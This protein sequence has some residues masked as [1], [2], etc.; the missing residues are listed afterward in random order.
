MALFLVGVDVCKARLDVYLQQTR[1]HRQYPNDAEGCRRLIA[2]VAKAAGGG[3]VLVVY[4]ATSIY[5]GRLRDALRQAGMPSSRANPRRSR[6]FARAAGLLAK[7]DKVDAVMLAEMGSALKLKCDAPPDPAAAA[8]TAL[9][10]RRGQL[11][12]ERKRLKT[13]M[14]QAEHA[15][16]TDILAE[17]KTQL[18]DLN[19]RIA[20]YGRKL[21]KRLKAAPAMARRAEI[22]RSLP[23]FGPVLSITYAVKAAELGSI[24]RRAAAALIGVAPLAC[25]SGLMRSK[26]HCWG[27]RKHLRNLLHMASLQAR[28]RGPFKALYDRLIEKGKA[29]KVALTAVGRKLV[30]IL[31]AL[32]KADTTYDPQY[33]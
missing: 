20:S 2:A 16:L 31:N 28:K 17:M 21:D 4:E 27:G 1:Q 7:T 26:R 12:D 18:A 13:Q 6:Q 24:D 14:K 33:A 29:K 25:D 10:D 8:I 30:T 23:G 32:L 22:A 5:D 3:D 15:G 19:A 9:L 11:V